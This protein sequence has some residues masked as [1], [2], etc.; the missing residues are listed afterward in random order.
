MKEA[1]A[2]HV[3]NVERD[4]Q[5]FHAV[6]AHLNTLPPAPSTEEVA[7]NA[8]AGRETGAAGAPP[9]GRNIPRPSSRTA[10]YTEGNLFRVSVPSNWRELAGS[11]VVTFAP[12]GA[13]GTVSG[14]S[15]FTHGVEI[16]VARSETHDLQTATAELVQSLRQSNPRLSPQQGYD[17]AIIGGRQGLHTA[18]SNV[19][20][21]TGGQEVVDIYTAQLSDGS[22]FYVLGVSPR[23]D[24]GVYA[25][26]FA[27]IVRSIRFTR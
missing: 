19:S 9:S 13:Y 21:V 18:A 8:N 4:S 22:L 7:R 17:R 15:V 20:D 3:G 25:N 1:Q 2:L 10:S 24:Y 12:E 5:Q 16:G 26:T 11:S 23:D 27:N 6:Q 14:N